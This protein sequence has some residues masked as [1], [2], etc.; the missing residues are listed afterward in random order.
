MKDMYLGI[1]PST[2]SSGFGVMDSEGNLVDYGVVKVDKKKLTDQEQVIHQYNSILE[3]VEKYNIAGI[4]CEDQ[5]Q[6]PNAETFKQLCRAAGSFMVLAAMKDIELRMFH[7]SSW[8]KITH[9]KG[10]VGK[11]H[12]RLWV[13]ETYNKEF[14]KAHNDITDAIGI[15]KAFTVLKTGE[16]K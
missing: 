6:G 14:K 10:N 8:R 4:G 2:V 13:N 16:T 9:G 1:D 3:L 7:P 11:E 5:F 12:T 15:A